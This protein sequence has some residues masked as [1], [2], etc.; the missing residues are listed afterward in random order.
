MSRP[1]RL[2]REQMPGC[3]SVEGRSIIPLVSDQSQRSNTGSAP[4][5]TTTHWSVVLNAKAG[6]SVQA[7]EAMGQLWQT[8]SRPIQAYIRSRGQN[9]TDAEEL[10]QQF[11]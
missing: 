11:F 2:P 1:T 6:D 8:Y 7:T 5:F 9:Q 3:F 4:W 10:T